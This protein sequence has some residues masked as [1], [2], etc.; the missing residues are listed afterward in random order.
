MARSHCP[1]AADGGKDAGHGT[2]AKGDAGKDEH[3]EAE[4]T[5]AFFEGIIIRIRVPIYYKEFSNEPL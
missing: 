4:M 2:A 3:G 5:E 1:R